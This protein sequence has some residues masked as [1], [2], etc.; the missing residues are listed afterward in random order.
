MGRGRRRSP[1]PAARGR[2]RWPA[3]DRLRHHGAVDG[4][5]IQSLNRFVDRASQSVTALAARLGGLRTHLVASAGPGA[6]PGRI[7]QSAVGVLVDADMEAEATRLRALQAQRQLGLQALTISNAA[8]SA[9]LRL[10]RP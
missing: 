2:S 5:E 7:Q 10:F 8:P 4:K 1:S 3:P 6:G 9:L